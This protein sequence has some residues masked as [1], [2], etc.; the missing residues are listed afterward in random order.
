HKLLV[1]RF[2]LDL[3]ILALALVI[4]TTIWVRSEE[5]YYISTTTLMWYYTGLP[6]PRE[7]GLASYLQ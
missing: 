5:E 3:F 6:M 7:L 2:L 4:M 1:L